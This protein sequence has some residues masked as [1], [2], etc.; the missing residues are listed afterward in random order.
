MPAHDVAGL[1]TFEVG[2]YALV[3]EVGGGDPDVLV[4]H[5]AAERFGDAFVLAP[6]PF[7]EHYFTLNKDSR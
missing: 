3:V 1:S 7:L 2:E 6:V 5:A 4:L